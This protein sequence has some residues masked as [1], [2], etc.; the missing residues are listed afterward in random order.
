MCISTAHAIFFYTEA[1]NIVMIDGKL[2]QSTTY[3]NKKRV[4]TVVNSK[5]KQDWDINIMLLSLKSSILSCDLL[6]ISPVFHQHF[7]NS[8]QI[9]GNILKD[10]TSQQVKL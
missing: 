1:I 3:G 6:L 9:Q 2:L 10:F 8:W 7:Y 4:A 5:V